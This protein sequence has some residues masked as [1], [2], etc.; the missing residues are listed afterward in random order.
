MRPKVGD[1]VFA[2]V[3]AECLFGSYNFE[4]GLFL[5]ADVHAVLSFDAYLKRDARVGCNEDAAA[6]NILGCSFVL[7]QKGAGKGGGRLV[8]V[9]EGDVDDFL[10]AV[11]QV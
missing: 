5:D 7:V 8:A 3:V 4:G 10:F 6:P 1:F 11:L 2:G 9:F